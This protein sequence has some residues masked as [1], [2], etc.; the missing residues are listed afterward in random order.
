MRQLPFMSL[1]A[2]LYRSALRDRVKNLRIY[3]KECMK[4]NELQEQFSPLLEAPATVRGVHS[5]EKMKI[6]EVN[7][8][9]WFCTNQDSAIFEWKSDSSGLFL[10]LMTA[11][12]I[13]RHWNAPTHSPWRVFDSLNR[14]DI[15]HLPRLFHV[16]EESCFQGL[17]GILKMLIRVLMQQNITKTKPL[18]ERTTAA[19]G[20][21]RHKSGSEKNLP[22]CLWTISFLCTKRLLTRC[23]AQHRLTE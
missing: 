16:I 2:E 13:K 19:A 3:E 17:W 15:I 1:N 4:S 22:Q 23:N 8:R 10:L 5:V 18:Q 21:T 7:G 14:T 20:E 11:L 9:Q 12:S 6:F